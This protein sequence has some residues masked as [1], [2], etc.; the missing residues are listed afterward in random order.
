VLH[1]TK[2]L[3][4]SFSSCVTLDLATNLSARLRIGVVPEHFSIP[5]HYG[6][7]NGIYTKHNVEAQIISLNHINHFQV[8]IE[9]FPRGTGSMCRSLRHD[10][11]DVAVALTEGIISDIAT[12]GVI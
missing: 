8:E 6:K 12:A 5:F 4:L 7:D 11:I 9:E 1:V 10:E 3:L 2:T